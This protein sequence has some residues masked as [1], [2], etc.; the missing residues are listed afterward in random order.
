VA[1]YKEWLEPDGLILLRKWKRDGLTDKAIAA[2]KLHISESTF[3][4]WSNK[5]PEFSEAIKGGR[6]VIVGKLEDTAIDLAL[7]GN[8]TMLIFVLCNMAPEKWRRGD[9]TASNG[10]TD[11]EDLTPL[12]ELLK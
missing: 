5:F 3:Y 1:K 12:A 9:A 10:D 6:E 8:V 4:D 7:K 2:D 11:I